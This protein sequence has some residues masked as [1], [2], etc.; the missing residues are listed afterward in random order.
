M[1][2]KLINQKIIHWDTLIIQKQPH[3]GGIAACK[4]WVAK[5]FEF[6][7]TLLNSIVW[8]HKYELIV[9]SPFEYKEKESIYGLHISLKIILN[10]F[11]G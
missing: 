4:H 10:S 8:S 6:E 1:L 9:Y 2:N 3:H 7:G 5:Q 11:I